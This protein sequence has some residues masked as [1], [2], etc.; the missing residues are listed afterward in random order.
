MSKPVITEKVV[1]A[2]IALL[3]KQKGFDWKI[4]R[5]YTYTP[6]SSVIPNS[7]SGAYRDCYRSG[8]AYTNSEWAEQDTNFKRCLCGSLGTKHPPISAPTYDMTI[9]WL[10]ERGFYVYAL[11]DML[12]NFYC[13]YNNYN[14]MQQDRSN[15]N[16][17]FNSR[18]EALDWGIR[19]ALKSM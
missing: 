9:D 16:L 14:A 11:I 18:Y 10:L 1:P 19:K 4:A 15:Q 13:V 5:F 12:P 17:I 2:D 3:L 6:K 8:I 7:P